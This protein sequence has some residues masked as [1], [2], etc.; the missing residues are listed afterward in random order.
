MQGFGAAAGG[1]VRDFAVV[2]FCGGYTTVSSFSL[3]T[4]GLGL[5]GQAGRAA[6][7]VLM[8]VGLCLLAVAGGALA[9][10]ALAG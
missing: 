1:W 4:L 2:G 6:L 8:S 7:N 9:A 3:Q 5:D 10:A